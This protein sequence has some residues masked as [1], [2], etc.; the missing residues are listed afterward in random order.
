MQNQKYLSVK[1]LSERYS[2]NRSSIWRWVKESKLPEPVK[3]HGSTRWRESD[4]IQFE[5]EMG[6]A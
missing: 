1:K 6:I 3:I 2:L 4:L 5:I